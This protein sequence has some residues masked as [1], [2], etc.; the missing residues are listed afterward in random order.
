MTTFNDQLFQLGGVPVGADLLGLAGGKQFFVDPSLGDDENAPGQ[1]PAAAFAS[2]ETA[3]AAL[4]T[5][6]NEIL[7][8]IAGASGLTMQAALDW[9]KSYTHFRGICAAVLAA[10]RARLFQLSTLTGAS[11][12]F[13]VSGSGNIFQ[14]FYIFQGVDD[15]TS[16]INFQVTGSRN[17]FRNVHFAGGGH[18]T[19][20]IDGGA[21]LHISGGSENLFDHCT[22][23]IDTIAAATGMAGLVFAATG[24]AA[25]NYFR[26]CLFLMYAGNANALFVEALGNSGIDRYTVFERCRFV[27]LSATTMT[28]AFKFAAGFDPANKRFLLYDCELIGATDWDSGDSG[29]LYLN[30]HTRTGGGNSGIMLASAAT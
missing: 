15:A 19:Q 13:K 21:S 29:M 6:K 14:D 9:D 22:I 12:L 7:N 2:L 1:S 26:D 3:E 23:G 8:Y 20:A 11:P 28:T 10:Q 5:N 30:S 17:I 24:G 4:T 16:L 18:A 27:N 25:R